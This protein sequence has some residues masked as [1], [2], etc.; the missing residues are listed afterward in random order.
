MSPR[1]ATPSVFM[2]PRANESLLLLLRT[3]VII[4]SNTALCGRGLKPSI[5]GKTGRRPVRRSQTAATEVAYGATLCSRRCESGADAHRHQHIEKRRLNFQNSRTHF[6]D[7]IE[8]DFV[9][10]QVAQRRHQK[11]RIEG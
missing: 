4:C 8:E 6:V 3:T 1:S 9:L 2:G 10:G 11:F 7:E 5:L